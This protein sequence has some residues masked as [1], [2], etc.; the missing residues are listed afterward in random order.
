[1]AFSPDGK[2]LASASADETVKLWAVADAG[3][4]AK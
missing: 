1:V 4:S 2:A 3:E